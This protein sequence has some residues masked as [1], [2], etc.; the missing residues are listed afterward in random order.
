MQFAVRGAP[1]QERRLLA[2]GG[3]GDGDSDDAGTPAPLAAV[4]TTDTYRPTTEG[5]ADDRERLRSDLVR[6]PDAP[7]PG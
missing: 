6:L 1:P 7:D 4:P 2:P 3:G 5:A